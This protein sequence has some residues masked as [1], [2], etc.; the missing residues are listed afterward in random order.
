SRV[1]A[2]GLPHRRLRAVGRATTTFGRMSSRYV[3]GLVHWASQPLVPLVTRLDT[4]FSKWAAR[5]VWL[6]RLYYG[7]W[8]SSFGREQL[9]VLSGRVRYFA[10]VH[11][12]GATSALLR[13]NCHRLEK[14]LLMV[15]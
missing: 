6:S 8:K 12:P 2:K 14:G 5:S 10:E 9:S 7:H 15:P 3:R 11:T 4:A 13:R 1:H